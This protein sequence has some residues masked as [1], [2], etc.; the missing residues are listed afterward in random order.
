MS[1]EI[2]AN[3]TV[4]IFN[5]DDIIYEKNTETIKS[6]IEARNPWYKVTDV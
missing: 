2:I 5:L 1:H 4:L 3:R 6:D